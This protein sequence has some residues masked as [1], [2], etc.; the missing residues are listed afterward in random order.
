V[1]P[2]GEKCI[3]IYHGWPPASND[4]HDAP[5]LADGLF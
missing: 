4:Y 3:K 5:E 2:F 1:G